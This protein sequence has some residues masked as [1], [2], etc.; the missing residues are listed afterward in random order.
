M[1]N[2]P[3]V[4]IERKE[5]RGWRAVHL[6]NGILHLAAVPDIGGRVMALDLDGYSFLYVDPNLA[7]KLFTP[8]EHLGD[9]T[10]NAWKNYGGDKTWPAPQ[11]WDN[12]DQWHGPP[13]P[14]LD[15]GRYSL[16]IVQASDDVVSIRMT[17]APEPLTGVQISRRV[18]LRRGCSRVQLGL[19]FK[20]TSDRPRRW[21]IWDVTQLRSER[22]DLSGVPAPDPECLITAP[23][24]P[25]SRFPDGYN[26]MF[27][28]KDNPQWTVDLGRQLFIAR[29]LFEIGKVGLDSSGEWIA[30][31]NGTAKK[32]FIVNFS[33]F[34]GEEYPD[35]GASLESWTVG[36]GKIPGLN[37]DYEHSGIYLMETEV[38]SPLFD[39]QPGETRSFN[40]EW[41]VCS[42]PGMVVQASEAG[43]V[44]QPLQATS[45]PDG[46]RLT[47]QFG[48]Y[49][50]GVLDIAWLDG[51]KNVL[52]AQSL[53]LVTPFQPLNLDL[54]FKPPKGTESVRLLVVADADRVVRLLAETKI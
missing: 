29:Y 24:N 46:V 43:P 18:T 52:L 14:V 44:C 42:L 27:A 50:Q 41:G 20:N 33:Y 17:S 23:I 6:S 9:G 8:N 1:T 10:A 47:G 26:V 36:R 21:S 28:R 7:G 37:Y 11:G 51:Y 48:V 40:L 35:N 12:D 31:Y 25:H 3:L 4:K 45:I 16:N 32:S 53:E 2:L 39:F 19:S 5:F 54:T 22:T 34:E 30:F 49:E 38:L 15:G 13:D